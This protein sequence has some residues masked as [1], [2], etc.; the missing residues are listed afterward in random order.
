[1]S[2]TGCGGAGDEDAAT[3]TSGQLTTRAARPS[4]GDPPAEAYQRGVRAGHRK[5]L[6]ARDV[7]AVAAGDGRAAWIA[8]GRVVVRAAGA[9]P[10]TIARPVPFG[11]DQIAI[12]ADRDGTPTVLL[13]S[14]ERPGP[15]RSMPADGSAPPTPVPFA[16]DGRADS[17]PGLRRGVVSF[18]R[19]ERVGGRLRHT[20]RTA[21]LDGRESVRRWDGAADTTVTRTLA[22]RGGVAFVSS[23]DG[24]EYG[25]S[26]ALRLTGRGGAP[27]RG[28]EAVDTGESAPGSFGA[29]QSTPDG[30]RLIATRWTD[31]QRSHPWDVTTF[32]APDGT[33]VERHHP[34]DHLEGDWGVDVPDG[35]IYTDMRHVRVGQ[36]SGEGGLV[37]RLRRAAP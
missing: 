34:A 25:S 15:L 23:D 8:D 22:V 10:R 21:R 33:L 14:S 16:A 6:L 11:A 20:V 28:L 24:Y 12:G 5:I 18:S 7:V 13:A 17:A 29:L 27:V 19:T 4:G 36:I 32:R 3:A 30:T 35:R 2:V 9:A 37:I 26:H 1:M 31:D